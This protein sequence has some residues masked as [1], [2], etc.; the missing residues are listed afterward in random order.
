MFATNIL[1][2]KP[3]G[4]LMIGKI[5]KVLPWLAKER[6][7]SSKMTIE[8]ACMFT[9]DGIYIYLTSKWMVSGVMK[10]N[11]SFRKFSLALSTIHS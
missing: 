7:L 1:K 6:L 11:S 8:E 2:R 10:E 5:E 4:F 3:K 9:L